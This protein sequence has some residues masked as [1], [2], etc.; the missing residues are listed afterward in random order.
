MIFFFECC[1]IVGFVFKIIDFDE[2]LCRKYLKN[3]RRKWNICDFMIVVLILK[4]ESLDS[5]VV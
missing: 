5:I 3:I 4:I 1:N 2:V